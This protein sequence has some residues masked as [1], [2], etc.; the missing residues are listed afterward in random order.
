METKEYFI[1]H[2]SESG[3]QIEGPLTQ[4][5]VLKK[6]TPDED[7]VTWYGRLGSFH[8]QVPEI[9]DGYFTKQGDDETRLL[10][11]KGRIVIPAAKTV[12]TAYELP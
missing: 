6:I 4:S 9:E 5:E 7:G 10:V 2:S 11:I 12:T 3:I 1:I 8:A